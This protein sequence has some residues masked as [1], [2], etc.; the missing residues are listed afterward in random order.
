MFVLSDVRRV[1]LKKGPSGLGFNIVGGEEDEGIFVSY[2]LPG[3]PADVS[4]AVHI[5]DQLLSVSFTYFHFFN[6]PI[7]FRATRRMSSPEADQKERKDTEKMMIT[8]PM[9]TASQNK[10]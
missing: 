3:G 7:F 5:G 1:V 4:G 9:I 10:Q 2:I 6:W 8:K